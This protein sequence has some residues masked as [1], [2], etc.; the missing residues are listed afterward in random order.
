MKLLHEPTLLNLLYVNRR[1]QI[2]LLAANGQWRRDRGVG[3]NFPKFCAVWKFLEI[4]NTKNAK[5]GAKTT[6]FG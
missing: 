3:D 5:F 1:L 6:H 4:K 2:I